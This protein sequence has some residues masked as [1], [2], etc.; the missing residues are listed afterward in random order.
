MVFAVDTYREG[1]PCLRSAVND[2][3]AIAA[4]L[5]DDHGFTVEARFEGEA[6]AQALMEL[7]ETRFA[8][9]LTAHDRLIVYFAGHG[10]A[11]DGEDGPAGYL[12]LAEAER[13]R[14]DSYLGM[15]RFHDALAQLRCR[16]VLVILDCCFAGTFRW[17]SLRDATAMSRVLYRERYDR[18]VTSAA[19]QVLTSASADQVALDRLHGDRGE[20]QGEHSPFA[21]ALLAALGGAADLTGDALITASELGVYLRE[22]VEPSV[23][24][25]GR[26]QTPQLF[27]LNKHERGEFVFQVPGRRLALPAAP[28]LTQENNPYLG[29]RSFE[30]EDAPRFFGRDAMIAALAA[31]VEQRRLTV[32]TGPS[33]AGKSSLVH[34]GLLPRLRA[35]RGWLLL[36]SVR[37]G[38]TPGQWLERWAAELGEQGA[39]EGGSSMSQVAEAADQVAAPAASGWA[40]TL[41]ALPSSIERVVI[42]IDQLEELFT[43]GARPTEVYAFVRALAEAIGREPRLHVIATLRS[44]FEAQLASGALAPWWQDGRFLV[45]PMGR[46]EL[47]QVIEGPAA[48]KVL[49][50]EP[51]SLVDRLI[52]DVG[53][54]PAKLPLLSFALQE[55]YR[56]F[57]SRHGEERAITEADYRQI[58]SVAASLTTRAEQLYREVADRSAEDAT[59]MRHVL[60]RLITQVAGKLVRRSVPWQDFLSGAREQDERVERVLHMLIDARLLVVHTETGGT[61]VGVRV[62]EPA[63]EELISGWPRLGG[64]THE[65]AQ[66]FA[67]RRELDDAAARWSPRREGGLLW[68]AGARLLALRA[69]LA[70][71]LHGLNARELAFG[72]ASRRRRRRQLATLVTSASLA[73]GTIVVAAVIALVQRNI[74]R[75]RLQAGYESVSGVLGVIDQQLEDL[76]GT[77]EAKLALVEEASELVTALVPDP[78]RD[79]TARRFALSTQVRRAGDAFERN[80]VERA[81]RE[82]DAA[83]VVADALE[84]TADPSAWPTIIMT[85][86]RAGSAWTRRGGRDSNERAAA[87]FRRALALSRRE[88]AR[89][90]GSAG[91]LA[92]AVPMSNLAEALRNLDQLDESEQLHREELALLERW[93]PQAADPDAFKSSIAQTLATLGDLHLLRR[94]RDE[95]RLSFER[96]AEVARSMSSGSGLS[97]RR[98]LLDL[99][100]RQIAQQPVDA[101][102]LSSLR[103]IVRLLILEGNHDDR[104]RFQDWASAC[105][106]FPAAQYE[107]AR[108]MV[109]ELGAE[110][111]GYERELGQLRVCLGH[112]LLVDKKHEDAQRE[113][114]AAATLLEGVVEREPADAPARE[115]LIKAYQLRLYIPGISPEQ[116]VA[117]VQRCQARAVEPRWREARVDCLLPALD[118]VWGP[119]AEYVAQ[120]L[121]GELPGMATA[122]DGTPMPRVQRLRAMLAVTQH[123][124]R[125]AVTCEAFR[126]QHADLRALLAA[127][128]QEWAANGAL[129]MPGLA[130]MLSLFETMFAGLAAPPRCS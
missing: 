118:L 10:L 57:W 41:A 81:L 96:A 13:S 54:A 28:A 71:P 117:W 24:A 94:Q 73:L 66:A 35:R 93:A 25:L 102:C 111:A 123:F 125:G 17:S 100:L 39:A 79:P 62:V 44:D 106:A 77:R 15:K 37:P 55:L 112:G 27:P 47:R 21:A 59:A 51:P 8:G 52:D 56:H 38:G 89:T 2:G 9:E 130:D 4:H 48:D 70:E 5:R 67:L 7:L 64:W 63:H 92:L 90:P 107:A 58:G 128:R 98:L 105:R 42:V 49:Y 32:V 87:Y 124:A 16:H 83:V 115:A 53:A 108:G 19:W 121:A 45:T 18:F 84:P 6:T 69:L 20:G 110:S 11:I 26:A 68:G 82:Y 95:A 127:T 114:E 126:A 76:P 36:S 60:L 46:E 122:E 74:A 86:V 72:H 103:E 43:Q 12:M 80:E 129:Q 119:S 109:A 40:A 29:L 23:E 91:A 75:D 97:R 104:R 30:E 3:R 31:H 14:P 34:A 113:I 61:N 101:R 120:A 33:G 116:V 99:E 50:F 65:S 78:E 22:Q 1:L 85:Y 88:Y